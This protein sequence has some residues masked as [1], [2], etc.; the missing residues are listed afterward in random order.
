MAVIFWTFILTAVAFAC[1]S[2][3]HVRNVFAAVGICVFGLWLA[4]TLGIGKF[5]F[6]YGESKQLVSVNPFTNTNTPKEIPN[7]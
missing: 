4:G 3:K 7:D 5:I 1:Y 2:F 6:Y